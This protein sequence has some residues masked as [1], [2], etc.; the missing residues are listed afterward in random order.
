MLADQDFGETEPDHDPVKHQGARADHVDPARV[1]DPDRRALGAGLPE[2]R[3]RDLVAPRRRDPGVMDQLRVVPLE[4]ERDPAD[5]G[6]RP[7][8]AYEG[9]GLPG[10]DAG[11]N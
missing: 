9:A 4:A 2:Q 6:D 1:H 5:R 7:G 11:G 8:Q 10:R 3:R